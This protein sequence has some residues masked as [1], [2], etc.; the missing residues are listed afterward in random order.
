MDLSFNLLGWIYLKVCVHVEEIRPQGEAQCRPHNRHR[1]KDT[2][3][4]KVQRYRNR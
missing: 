4:P 3:K 1:L 2:W